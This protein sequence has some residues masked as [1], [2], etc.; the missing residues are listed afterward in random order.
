MGRTI[1]PY[2]EINNYTD[3]ELDRNYKS[4][5]TTSQSDIHPHPN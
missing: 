5:M 1:D 2:V 4:F 3:V